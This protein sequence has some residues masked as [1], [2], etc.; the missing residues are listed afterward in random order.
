M[1][2]YTTAA[3]TTAAPTFYTPA[4]LLES[5]PPFPPQGDF[6]PTFYNPF[7]I[8]HRR[9]TSRAQLKVL[10][11]SF[12][13]NAK[14]NA[15]VRRMLAQKLDMTPRGVQI[16]F[17]NRRAKAKLQKR[18]AAASQQQAAS[19]SST[20]QHNASNNSNNTSSITTPVEQQQQQQTMV[21]EHNNNTNMEQSVL[22]SQFSANIGQACMEYEGKPAFA[23]S[24][25]PNATVTDKSATQYW[26]TTSSAWPSNTESAQSVALAAAAAAVNASTPY[27]PSWFVH[28]LQDDIN[29][30][31]RRNSCPVP[32]MYDPYFEVDQCKDRRVSETD[33]T[34]YS[35]M[36]NACWSDPSVIPVD[37]C[38]MDISLDYGNPAMAPSTCSGS[39][40]SNSVT[41]SPVSYDCFDCLSSE[42]FLPPAF[43]DSA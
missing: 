37:F 14:P 42:T 39:S 11:K 30:A 3:A 41:D 9:R 36:P 23:T 25:P 4:E 10:E 38:N 5:F 40:T 34:S 13:E 29:M 8:K 24:L 6:R 28:P 27:D 43:H 32:N 18:K 22:F 19:S 35:M 17:Q 16:W 26:P 21:N 12:A 33:I 20:T 1:Q 15:A 2:S 7:E 31:A